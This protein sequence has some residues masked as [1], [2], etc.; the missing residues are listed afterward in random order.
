MKILLYINTIYGGGAER[1]MVN[2]ANIFVKNKNNVILVTSYRHSGEYQAADRVKRIYFEEGI[3]KQS[4]LKRN[5]SRIT[6]LRRIIKNE[7]P[8][9]A[10]SFMEESNYRL[11]F[12]GFGL[13]IH[14]IVSIR[15]DPAVLFANKIKKL[16]SE[17]LYLT[18][19]GI[20]FQTQDAM[21]FFPSII[22]KKSEVIYN[23]VNPAF[24]EQKKHGS[25]HNVIAVGRLE[26]QKNFTLL[27]KAFVRIRKLVEDATLNIYGCG[28]QYDLLKKLI[29][30]LELMDCVYLRGVSN[31]LPEVFRTADIFVMSSDYEGMPNALMEAM[32]SGLACLSTNCPCG[33][34]KELF[35]S[36]MGDFLFQCGNQI[37][38]EEK[39]LKLLCSEEAKN[40]NACYS[41][42]RSAIF[43]EKNIYEKWM[44]YINIVRKR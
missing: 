29:C 14:T 30:E 15:N 39:L 5:F 43:C 24:Y 42:R 22:R 18:A 41:R 38:L 27:I 33:G 31:H 37:E 25:G 3:I 17:L 19:D 20:V 1:A 21:D 2:L 7:K 28:T 36:E 4:L 8:D 34:P 9:I 16:F 35:G 11:L 6:K 13:K 40:N 23:T 44:N 10:I 32:A 26:K 12:A